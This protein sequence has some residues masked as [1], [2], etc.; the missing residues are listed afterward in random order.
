MARYR[1]NAL[2]LGRL[3]RAKAAM[4]VIK[5]E[6]E[7]DILRP[8]K[9]RALRRK[10]QAR[11]FKGGMTRKKNKLA[12]ARR[13][14]VAARRRAAKKRAAARKRADARRRAAARRKR[15]RGR[16]RGRRTGRRP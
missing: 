10:H 5:V 12:A 1:R 11:G 9:L 6:E 13:L 7:A 14:A 4:K 8:G 16:G 3:K 15:G 2:D